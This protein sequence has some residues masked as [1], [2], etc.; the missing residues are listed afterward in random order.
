MILKNRIRDITYMSLG[1]EMSLSELI[2]YTKKDKGR[3]I[4][5][6][7]EY[8]FN[9]KE[10]QMERCDVHYMKGRRDYILAQIVIIEFLIE[11]LYEI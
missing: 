2:N 5:A 4:H 6:L 1:K 7:S 3:V 9:L 8:V 11:S 10:L